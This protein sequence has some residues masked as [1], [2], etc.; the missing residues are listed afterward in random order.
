MVIDTTWEVCGIYQIKNLVTGKS[1]VGSAV[2][3]SR[4]WSLH[5]HQLRRGVH[6]SKKL[7]RAWNK[8]SQAAFSFEVLE[9]VAE[10]SELVACEQAWIDKT[11]CVVDGYNVKPT[12]G[13]S[14]GF[15]FS[16]ESRKK[17]SAI[18][19]GRPR[20]LESRANQSAS[21]KGKP[22]SPEHRAKL[23]AINKA[24]GDAVQKTFAVCLC[25]GKHFLSRPSHVARGEGKY[26]TR[27]C[28]K[29][30]KFGAD[31]GVTFRETAVDPETGEIVTVTRTPK[32]LEAA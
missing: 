9:I 25:C 28:Y 21:T 14:L 31:A 16:E 5:K 3:I 7:Q 17:M 22:K 18:Q 12:A 10:V 29:V 19:V 26:C 13:S 1:Y 32:R 8:H 23:A 15:V 20:S 30:A 27:S 24:R 11:N 2:N 6:H 4:R